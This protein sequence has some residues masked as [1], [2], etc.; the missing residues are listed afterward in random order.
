LQV[1]E[2]AT[3]VNVNAEGAVLQNQ[4]STVATTV[5]ANTIEN[6][7]LSGNNFQVAAVFVPGAVLPRFDLEGGSNGFERNTNPATLPSF[8]GNR[9]QGN[10]YILDGV[11]INEPTNNLIGYNPAPQ[12]LQ[13]MRTITANADAE[14]GD[15]NGGEMVLVT[16]GG[17]N[18]FHG[19]AYEYYENQ[20]LTANLWSNN[21]SGLAKGVFHQ[22]IFG[23]TFGGPVLRNKLFFF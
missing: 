1:G 8:N 2:V 15:V 4:S 14:Y 22:N 23:V 10:N 20:A 6:L 19:S 12:A 7:P 13:E 11:E 16:K 18:Q 17:T 9:Q 21:Y 5:T 3:T